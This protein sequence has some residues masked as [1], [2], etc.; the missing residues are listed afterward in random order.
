MEG[1]AFAPVV[2]FVYNRPEHTAR[3]VE[4]LKKNYGAK[5]TELFVFCDY[6]K[7]EKALPKMEETR[8][9]V[10][11]I[12]G[13]KDVQIRLRET[14][15]GLAESVI[16]GVTE[17]VN[18][19]GRVIV[20]EDDLVTGQWFLTYMNDALN[21]YENNKKVFSVT[22]YSH[23]IHGSN[24][25]PESYFL[26]VFSS[27]SW[28]VWKDRWDLFDREAK[29]WEEIKENPALA[30]A[31][32]YDNCLDNCTMLKNQMEDRSINS[33]A[34]RAYWTMFRADMTTLFPNMRLCENI[35]NDGSG[36]HCGADNGY[37]ST[38]PYNGRILKFPESEEETAAA[39]SA[40]IRC[41]KKQKRSYLAGRIG[42][43]LRHPMRAFQKIAHR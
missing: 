35:G 12:T 18:R 37:A 25:L 27:W 39:K 9:Y 29:G 19:F 5:E 33:W 36:V 26:K 15:F 16:S 8:A 43:Y 41:K 6:A 31:F 38:E 10:A 17:V 1:K 34:I 40:F 30:K 23:F 2:L 32:D 42:F 7:N 4:A 28:A 11:R 3:T 22:G 21:R 20:M 24:A 14:N 13:F